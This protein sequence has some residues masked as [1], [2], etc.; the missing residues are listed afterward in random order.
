MTVGLI[1]KMSSVSSAGLVSYRSPREKKANAAAKS[2]RADKKTAK[3]A[4][5]LAEAEAR[6]LEAQAKALEDGR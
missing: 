5:R 2:A 1:R 6:L 3:A 4:A